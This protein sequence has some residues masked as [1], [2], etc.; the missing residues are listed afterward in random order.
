M[1]LSLGIAARTKLRIVIIALIALIAASLLWATL[2]SPTKQLDF[3]P[4]GLAFTLIV[5]YILIARLFTKSPWMR[6]PF[7]V[8]MSCGVLGLPVSTLLSVEFYMRSALQPV[9]VAPGLTTIAL[10]A[11]LGALS[12]VALYLDGQ[13]RSPPRPPPEAL[14]R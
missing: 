1:P 3:T 14:G 11:A 6:L 12:A 2:H 9:A 8:V 10:V 7:V 13:E 4:T 5:Y